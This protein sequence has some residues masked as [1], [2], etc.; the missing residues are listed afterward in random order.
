[1]VIVGLCRMPSRNTV[2][3]IASFAPGPASPLVLLHVRYGNP[4]CRR[5]AATFSMLVERHKACDVQE[6]S[7]CQPDPGATDGAF[8]L[9]PRPVSGGEVAEGLSDQCT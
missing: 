3:S 6:A 9:P 7:L 5:L 1:M 4:R 8:I 2:V